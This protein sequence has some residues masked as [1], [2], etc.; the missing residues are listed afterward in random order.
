MLSFSSLSPYSLLFLQISGP[1][2]DELYQS[3]H[4]KCVL[5]IQNTMA[6][7]SIDGWTTTSHDPVLAVAIFAG[8]ESYLMDAVDTNG[9]AHTSENEVEFPLR[10][11]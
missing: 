2:L 7:I 8:E 11:G 9:V 1:L 4:E 10:S 3:E 6:T 5:D